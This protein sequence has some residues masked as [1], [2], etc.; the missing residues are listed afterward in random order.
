M[1]YVSKILSQMTGIFKP[2]QKAIFA[3]LVTVRN[4]PS[5]QK[6]KKHHHQESM[7]GAPDEEPRRMGQDYRRP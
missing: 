4:Y 7:R 5:W 3:L 2:Q 1:T 6:N